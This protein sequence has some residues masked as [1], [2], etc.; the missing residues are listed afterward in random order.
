MNVY[1]LTDLASNVVD[2]YDKIRMV[3]QPYRGELQSVVALA[4]KIYGNY[5]S[6]KPL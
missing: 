3:N 5:D 1:G 6:S 2:D 4:K